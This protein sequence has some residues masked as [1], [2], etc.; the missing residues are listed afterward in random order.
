VKIEIEITLNS[1]HIG[2]FREVVTLAIGGKDPADK[3]LSKL[4]NK[5]PI[6]YKALKT[7]IQAIAD[8]EKTENDQTFRE[9]GGGIFEFK[10][11][12]PKLI[13][14]YAFYDEIEGIGHLIL[15]TNGGDKRQQNQ[16]IQKAKD[17]RSLYFEAKTKPNTKIIYQE[18]QK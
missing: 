7:R 11:N 2:E 12:S 4:K 1:I 15:C 9:V 5:D 18:P 14:L 3:F 8:Y 16:D 10:R 13:R 17:I 6:A